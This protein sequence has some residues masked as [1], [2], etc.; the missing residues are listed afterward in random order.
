MHCGPKSLTIVSFSMGA[1]A[2]V[3]LV[4]SVSTDAWLFTVEPVTGTVDNQT[5]VINMNVRSGLW[6][7]CTIAADGSVAP[8][9][10]TVSYFGDPGRVE[11]QE[12]SFA[13]IKSNRVAAMI[14]VIS[15]ILLTIAAVLSVL[16]NLRQDIKTLISAV[17]YILAGLSLAVGLILYIS[18][19][20]DEVG[21]RMKE[22]DKEESSFSYTYGWSFYFAGT[23]FLCAMLSAVIH[24]SL[25]LQRNSRKEEMVR[26]IPGLDEL[27]ESDTGTA[28]PTV[29][30]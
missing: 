14:P 4:L 21:H 8:P 30:I 16:G 20:N 19:I 5:F 29:I 28:N 18:V 1:I 27:L 23:A 22:K 11:G 24:V 10:L 13:I 25:Y 3:T 9:C 17:I 2:L 15:L 6:R 26:V 12:T 7:V